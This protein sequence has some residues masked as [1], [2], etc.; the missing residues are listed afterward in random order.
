MKSLDFFPVKDRYVDVNL[1]FPLETIYYVFAF[2]NTLSRS[3]KG[4]M[5]YGF[6]LIFNSW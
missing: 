3:L 6:N 5:I 1:M 2:V 4:L